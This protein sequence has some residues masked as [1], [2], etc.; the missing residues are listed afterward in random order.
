MIKMM[1]TAES[2]IL[3]V[4]N[5]RHTA[6]IYVN[7]SKIEVVDCS[8]STNCRI[9][10]VKGGGCPSYC[11]F[12]VDAKRYVQGLRTKYRVEVLNPSS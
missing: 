4:K 6:V 3:Q 10:G 11:P 5:R 8:N 9:Q 2:T 12:V 1:I 7:G